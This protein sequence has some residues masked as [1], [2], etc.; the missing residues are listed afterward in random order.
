[1]K[2]L[3]LAILTLSLILPT[4]VSALTIYDNA[5]PY[6]TNLNGATMTKQ[7]YDNLKRAFD[8]DTIATMT[9]DTVNLL[10]NDPSLTSTE[11]TKYIQVDEYY[12]D[13]GNIIKTTETEVSEEQANAFVEAKKS[14]VVLHAEEN[15]VHQTSMKRLTISI[16]VG[17]IS[18]KTVTL[19]NTWLSLPKTRSFD[20]IAIRPGSLS[21]TINIT[22]NMISGYQKWDGNMITYDKNSDN[23]KIINSMLSQGQGGI[24][25][26]MN[27]VDATQY[28]L[29]NSLTVVFLSGADPFKAYGSYQHAQSDVSLAESKNYSINKNGLGEVIDFASSV[30]SKYDKMGGV[31]KVW[32]L[33][34]M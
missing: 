4:F 20:V 12:D 25:I 1:M 7:Q 21:A 22:N 8:E 17:S 10:K 33:L 28:S 30:R 2:K 29:E 23:T 31:S 14:E 16:S 19:T 24:G 15:P 18:A 13:N 11:E 34:D 26:S 5:V 32:T 3:F 9:V 6:Y 27:I